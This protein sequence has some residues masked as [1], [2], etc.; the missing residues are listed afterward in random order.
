MSVYT[1]ADT[2]FNHSNIIKYTNRPFKDV[3]EM[4]NFL[5]QEWN[6]TVDKGDYVF[7]CGD[8][9]FGSFEERK[10]VISRLNGRIILIRGNHDKKTKTHY[11]RLGVKGVY[12]IITIKNKILTHYPKEINENKI[13]I[14][15]HTHGTRYISDNHICVSVEETN[16]KPIAL[17][18]I[19]KYKA[20]KIS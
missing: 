13:N 15:G 20:K 8:L 11:K 5:I 17:S 14:H 16:Y 7:H 9:V 6:K 3:Q 4:N 2:H 18:D 10:E 12:K 1:T 19:K